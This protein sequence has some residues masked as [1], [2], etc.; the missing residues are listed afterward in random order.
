M[1]ARG[2]RL[3]GQ[4][5]LPIRYARNARLLIA[6]EG[7]KVKVQRVNAERVSLWIY[8][9]QGARRLIDRLQSAPDAPVSDVDVWGMGKLLGYADREVLQFIDRS[10]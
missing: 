10:M 8:R 7:C 9:E 2:V 3:A 1:V 6:Q 5:T 4:I